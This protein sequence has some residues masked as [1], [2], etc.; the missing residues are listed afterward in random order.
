MR[1]FL[2]LVAVALVV[3]G[4]T[5]RTGDTP[6]AASFNIGDCV[7][8]SAQV[9]AIDCAE[10]TAAYEVAIVLAT[11]AE[12]CPSGDYR[13]VE[14]LCLMLNAL[15]GDCFSGLDGPTPVRESCGVAEVKVSLVQHVADAACPAG[16][17]LVY[18]EP[19]PGRTVCLTDL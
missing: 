14:K 13:E 2:T 18:P 19:A 3:A 4:C 15:T 12:P 10:P 8:I 7:D 16:T 17:P 5:D 1:T 6:V 11:T 9:T